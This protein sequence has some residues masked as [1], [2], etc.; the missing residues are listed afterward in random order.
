MQEYFVLKKGLSPEKR[1][2]VLFMR[3]LGRDGKH[4]Q[5]R[6]RVLRRRIIDPESL[7]LTYPA[8][9]PTSYPAFKLPSYPAQEKAKKISRA[10]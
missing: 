10:V 6:Y 8:I 1:N 5:Q 4:G 2:S 9:P 3:Y 7:K